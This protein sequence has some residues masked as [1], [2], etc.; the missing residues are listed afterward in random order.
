M[1]NGPRGTPAHA[2]LQHEA[3]RRKTPSCSDPQR[4]RCETPSCAAST[5]DYNRRGPG[6]APDQTRDR[7]AALPRDELNSPLAWRR[8]RRTKKELRRT[9]EALRAAEARG[10]A[11]HEGLRVRVGRGAVRRR[12]AA[13]AGA[14][15]DEGER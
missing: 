2:R 14:A 15:P 5:K 1:A 10:A 7:M 12:G 9:E 8:K 4:E 3:N 11:A 6:Q 13:V